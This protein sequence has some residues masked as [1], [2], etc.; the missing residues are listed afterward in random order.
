MRGG[1][2]GGVRIVGFNLSL[3]L[4]STHPGM[5]D[6]NYLTFTTVLYFSSLLWDDSIFHGILLL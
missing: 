2:G 4:D 1:G 6:H 3:V 5:F